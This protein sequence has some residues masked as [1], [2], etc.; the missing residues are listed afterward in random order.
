MARSLALGLVLL[1]PWACGGGPAREAGGEGPHAERLDERAIRLEG[2][3]LEELGI[4]LEV[5]G[6]G[7]LEITTEVP[8]EVQVNGDRMAHVGPRVS[9]VA[10][11]VR[12]T[13]GDRV[14][15][16]QVL[17]V[18]E[19]RDLADAKATYLAAVER[20]KL[21]DA[22]F[23]R[24]ERLWREMVS[25]EQDY[26]DAANALAEARIALRTA[27]QK[28]HALGITED[29]VDRLSR[30][31]DTEYTRYRLTAP[32]DG[33]II[34][35]HI[36]VGE[37]IAA[38]QT[39]FTV[40]DLSTVWIDLRVYPKDLADVAP[41]QHL[42]FSAADGSLQG[43]GTIGFVQPLLGE[44]TRTALA[45][46]VVA[47]PERRWKPGLFV[48]GSVTV[49]TVE[50]AVLVPRSA[51]IRMD[52]GSDVVFVETDEG[53]LPRPVV[54]GRSSRELA[55]V[56]SGLAAGERFVARGGFSLKAELG[57]GAFGDPHGH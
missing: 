7:V 34:D 24:E 29:E 15:A 26:L 8:G 38:E 28:L 53:L 11:D 5:A 21:A 18:L 46:V 1:G 50:V 41:G 27:E 57:K 19:S 4:E 32:F 55:E 23:Q 20:T 33:E 9:G 51:L 36:T 44:D 3:V 12:A 49:D 37:T 45:R 47:N 52:D 6:P 16:G 43:E 54:A 17:A 14:S 25:A 13:L 22:T 10:R 30:Q 48:N 40:A 42:R 35:R 56:E 31:P 39:V 2:P